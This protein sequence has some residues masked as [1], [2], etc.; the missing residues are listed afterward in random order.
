MAFSVPAAAAT[1]TVGPGQTYAKPCAAIAAAQAGDVIQVDAAGS[2][3]GDTCAWST[4]N[5]TVTGVNG[6]AKIDLTGVAPAGQK[7]I[8]TIEGTASATIENFELSGAAI[9]AADGNNGAG[10][11]HQGLNLTVRSCFIHDNQDGILGAP[12]TPNTGTVLIENSEL[13]AN[14]A[15][16]GYSH[17]LYIGDYAA[18]TL[19]FSYSHD[20]KVGHLVKS[21]A[22]TTYLLYNRITDEVG[23][24]ASYETDL[25]NGGTAYLIG[26][27][28]EQSATTQNPTIVS[29]G[30][31]GVPAGYDTHL[32]VVNDTILN[33]LGSGTFVHDAT[34][35]PAV[36]TNTIFYNGG[37]ITDQAA[38]VLTTDFDSSMGN[39][40]FVDVASYDVRLLPGSPCIDHGTGPGANGAQSLAPVFEYVH[41]LGEEA[42]AV[43]GAAI[44]IGAYEY[45]NP[46]DAGVVEDAS[47]R[48]APVE[49]G[50]SSQANGLPDASSAEDAQAPT[51]AED[52]GPLNQSGPSGKATSNGCGCELEGASPT[53]PWALCA[54]ATLLA[55]LI[56][57]R[58]REN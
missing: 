36:L 1:L 35:T 25:P 8:F 57:R 56:A 44:D 28:L 40:M 26:N 38:A 12:A 45:G 9:S 18:F 2:Y 29:F 39:P 3:D 15:G 37:T 22:Y 58:R 6:R 55:G 33:T 23:G 10:I 17:N 51:P 5:L 48:G 21:R 4:D 27:I 24:M 20:A 7:G 32:F 11:R 34:M 47:G 16:D 13:S 14:G 53:G 41:P 52:A 49:G 54:T 50:P 31:E 19:K 43:V 30:E 42:R 46:A